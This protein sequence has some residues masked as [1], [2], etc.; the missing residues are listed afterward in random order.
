[1]AENIAANSC[2]QV[3]SVLPPLQD[4]NVGTEGASSVEPLKTD[5]IS[6]SRRGP[7]R[8][9]VRSWIADMLIG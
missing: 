6:S 1:M 8:N 5:T 4:N 2:A 7:R 3:S 9:K